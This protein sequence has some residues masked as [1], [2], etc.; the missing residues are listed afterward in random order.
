M[1]GLGLTLETHLHIFADSFS[2]QTKKSLRRFSAS[3]NDVAALTWEPR[4]RK[5]IRFTRHSLQ[6]CMLSAIARSE[7]E[8]N[9][10]FGRMR[11]DGE[12][13]RWKE[14]RDSWRGSQDGATMNVCFDECKHATLTS[15]D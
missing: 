1:S 15:L 12:T 13:D 8:S 3:E 5:P 4:G 7:N 11:H 6:L 2:T 9:T 10:H 14:K